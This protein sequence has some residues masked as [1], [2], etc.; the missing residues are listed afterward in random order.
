MGPRV[1]TGRAFLGCLLSMVDVAAVAA[2]P[3]DRLT[4]LEDPAR[5]DVRQQVKVPLLVLLLCDGYGLEDAGDLAEALLYRGLGEAGV[6]G[7]VLV[8]LPCGGGLQVGRGVTDDSR[9]VGCLYLGLPALQELE[10]PLGVLLLVQRRLLEYAGY[11]DVAV[12]PGLGGEVVVPVPR[13]GLA[14]EDR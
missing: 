2:S 3:L 11:L 6:H 10:Q 4:P 7:G 8:V 5:L 13:L 14:G 9:W 1:S 12:L